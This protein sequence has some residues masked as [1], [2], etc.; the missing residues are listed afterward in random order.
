MG[1][2]SPTCRQRA[3]EGAQ[4][5]RR[6]ST[7]IRCANARELR[8]GE[9]SELRVWSNDTT[10]S[11]RKETEMGTERA[12]WLLVVCAVTAVMACRGAGEVEDLG[13]IQL[14]VTAAPPGVACLRITAT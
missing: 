7:E 2:R 1:R 10:A 3:R 14:A 11:P 6:R 9:V 4:L 13:A 12:R 8:R 5:G